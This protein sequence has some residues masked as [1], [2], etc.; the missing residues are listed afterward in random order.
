MG[1]MV[2]K[3]ARHWPDDSGALAVSPRLLG[4]LVTTRPGGL[5]GGA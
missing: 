4:G 3:P 1:H 2:H 5:G